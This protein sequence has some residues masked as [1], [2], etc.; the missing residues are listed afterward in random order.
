MSRNWS[1]RGV[2]RWRGSANLRRGSGMEDIWKDKERKQ[3]WNRHTQA[4]SKT[5][6]EKK[7]RRGTPTTA[8]TRCALSLNSKALAPYKVGRPRAHAHQPP[9]PPLTCHNHNIH[10]QKQKQQQ[11]QAQIALHP[12]HHPCPTSSATSVSIHCDNVQLCV[13]LYLSI[14]VGY[15]WRIYSVN[16]ISARGSLL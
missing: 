9:L 7:G 8:F 15:P 5:S 4:K 3:T 2:R 14:F 10:T 13:S 12:H 16:D 1:W 11:M 6:R